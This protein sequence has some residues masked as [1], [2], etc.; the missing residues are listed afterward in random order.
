MEF[1]SLY[2]RVMHDG[3]GHPRA[4]HQ[5]AAYG[6]GAALLTELVI[7]ARIK[8]YPDGIALFDAPDPQ[9]RLIR[10]TFD[11]LV[12]HP[13]QTPKQWLRQLSYTA[14]VMTA[15][16]LESQ[17][18]LWMP[19]GEPD[20][21]ITERPPAMFIPVSPKDFIQP[22]QE[23]AYVVANPGCGEPWHVTWLAGLALAT[24]IGPALG[25][26]AEQVHAAASGISAVIPY[27]IRDLLDIAAAC[28][29]ESNR[30]LTRI[31]HT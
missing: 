18:H 9:E 15:M 23:V 4:R 7:G 29:A 22:F 26:P 17:Q 5:S 16:R 21:Q 20:Y 13:P 6:L 25:L 3:T 24:G 27:E 30:N 12:L 2:Y 28:C 31:L 11:T 14:P 8:V 19:G 10:H 1:A